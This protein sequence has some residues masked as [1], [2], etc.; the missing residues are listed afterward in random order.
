MSSEGCKLVADKF[1]IADVYA[2]DQTA[3]KLTRNGHFTV[4][5]AY[6]LLYDVFSL[7]SN[8]VWEMIWSVLISQRIWCFV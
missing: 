5:I 1:L 3:W 7:A 4:K 2:M 8:L 6:A